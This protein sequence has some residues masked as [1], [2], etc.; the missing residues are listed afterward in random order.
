MVQ[1]TSI[2]LKEV[3]EVT[4]AIELPEINK[5]HLED[6]PNLRSFSNG[7]II[8][9]SSLENVAVVN[10]SHNLK[11]FAGFATT[12]ALSITDENSFSELNEL[13][14][15]SCHKMVVVVSSK[16]LQELRN[17]KRLIVSHWKWYSRFMRKY[18]IPQGSYSN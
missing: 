7:N 5:V 9:W 3:K 18:L 4:V 8:E 12:N 16:T 11:K 10:G 13:K 6:L 17:L 1:V 14:L 2:L 15:D